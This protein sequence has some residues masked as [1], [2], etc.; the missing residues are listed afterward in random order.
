MQKNDV[1][2][3]PER[4]VTDVMDGDAV[5]A[6]LNSDKVLLQFHD[7]KKIPSPRLRR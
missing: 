4:V 3:V 5:I 2:C 7:N 1:V 6:N